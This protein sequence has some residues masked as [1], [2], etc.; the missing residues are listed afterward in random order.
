MCSLLLLHLITGS[1][2]TSASISS[3]W[4][5][6]ISSHLSVSVPF[7]LDSGFWI[8]DR[9]LI[10]ISHRVV[11]WRQPAIPPFRILSSY[12]AVSLNTYDVPL[13]MT[14]FPSDL[15]QLQILILPRYPAVSLTGPLSFTC[16]Y[17]ILDLSSGRYAMVRVDRS[18]S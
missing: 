12:I 4:S 17:L 7:C 16:T 8:L 9:G 14:R 3:V 10:L 18:L 11:S 5:H 6:L 2:Q 1:D 15:S 13:P